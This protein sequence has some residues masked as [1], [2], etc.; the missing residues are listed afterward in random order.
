M[1]PLYKKCLYPA[2]YFSLGNNAL[3]FKL[4][5][6]KKL[7][8]KASTNKSSGKKQLSNIRNCS[9]LTNDKIYRR[10]KSI[11]TSNTDLY[12]QNYEK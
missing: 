5:K 8:A 10:K 4:N 7:A 1:Q 3:C 12:L 11:M 6:K 2:Q 9:T